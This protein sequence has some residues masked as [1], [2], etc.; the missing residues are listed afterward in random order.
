[1][2]TLVRRQ[3]QQRLAV[4]IHFH[5]EV[6]LSEVDFREVLASGQ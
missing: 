2:Q 5:L 1:M 3:S 4:L 6:G